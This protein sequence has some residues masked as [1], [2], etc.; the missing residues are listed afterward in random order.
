MLSTSSLLPSALPGMAAAVASF[1]DSEQ[2]LTAPPSILVLQ[3]AA[4]SEL[5]GE[6][7]EFDGEQR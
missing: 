2:L 1:H 3:T 7:I 5:P 4:T 6:P